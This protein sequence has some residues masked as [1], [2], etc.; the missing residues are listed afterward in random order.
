M[1]GRAGAGEANSNNK[2]YQFWQQHNKPIELATNEM[3]DRYMNY[4]HE[5]PVKAGYVEHAEDYV[6]SSAP[7]IGGKPG[8]LELEER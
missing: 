5:N 1:Q 4:L 8:L 7:A 2:E 3:I 6:Y